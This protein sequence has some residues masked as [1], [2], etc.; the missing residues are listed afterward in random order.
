MVP[1]L[2]RRRR[3][4][5][6]AIGGTPLVELDRIA[7]HGVRLFA[8]LE[9]FNPGGSAKDR[10]SLAML[11]D[12]LSKGE[13]HSDTV[14]V[15]SSSGNMGIGLAQAC[16]RLGL[17]FVC[18]TDVRTSGQNI[19]LMR[20]YGAEVIIV[21]CDDRQATGFLHAR[22]DK[23]HEVLRTTPNAYW[24]NQYKNL[25]T[26]RVHREQTA[27][28]IVDALGQFPETVFVPVSTCGTLAGLLQYFRAKQATT[29]ICAV[30]LAGSVIFGGASA[31][32]LIPGLGSSQQPSLI[33]PREVDDVV[34]VSDFECVVGCRV[35]ASREAILGGGSS[36]AV[37]SAAV[38]TMSRGPGAGPNV[39]IFPDRG[40][41]YLDTIFDDD[42][43]RRFVCPVE[44]LNDAVERFRIV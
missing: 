42:W 26:V 3:G 7:P 44:E 4:V 31:R 40:E 30:D 13:I 29:R 27:G 23:V 22:I 25:A 16:R 36:G 18:V 21:G 20:A 28:E 38:R 8:K 37:L 32:R 35:L 6:A 1:S 39:L 15:E 11:E 2:D 19:R 14:I 9:G 24:P 41:R 10:S 43:V 5:L 17:R 12:G 33:D 34:H